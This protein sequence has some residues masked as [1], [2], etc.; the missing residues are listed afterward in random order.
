ML[1]NKDFAEDVTAIRDRVSEIVEERSEVV[2]ILH[3]Y[4]GLPGGE[5]WQ[6]LG[7]KQ[8]AMEGKK[9]GVIRLVFVMAYVVPE[10]FQ[11]TPKGDTSQMPPWMKADV[12]VRLLQFYQFYFPAH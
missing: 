3:S 12:E 7:M 2:V 4:G 1:A 9:G 6:G 11:P 8:R 10:G 5:V